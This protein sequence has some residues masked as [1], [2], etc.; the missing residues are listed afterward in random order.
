MMPDNA[1]LSEMIQ[2]MN[3]DNG[4]AKLIQEP[5]YAPGDSD[6]PSVSQ[7]DIIADLFNVARLDLK[8]IGEELGLEMEV[9]RMTPAKA[10]VLM[11]N[12]V[13]GDS[14]EL[15][16]K[17]NELEAKRERILGAL[18]DSEGEY[19]VH[20][21]TKARIAHS[22]PDAGPALD[23]GGAEPGSPD[24]NPGGNTGETT[25]QEGADGADGVDTDTDTDTDADDRDVAEADAEE[26]AEADE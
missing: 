13:Q 25:T 7:A 26:G 11:Q 20:S 23:D 5:V 4:M 14:L 1:G 12:M 24:A 2:I 21:E 10:A 6:E 9:E 22:R 18:L 16:E 19:D 17:F 3:Q 15:I 8:R